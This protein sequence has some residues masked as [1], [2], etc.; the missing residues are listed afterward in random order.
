VVSSLSD[1]GR[2]LY[3]IAIN[4]HFDEYIDG[5]IA[6]RS[7]RP[8]GTATVRILQGTGI[9]AHTGTRLPKGTPWAKQI[10]D[11]RNPRFGRGGPDEV[12]VT[13][14][15]VPISDQLTYRFPPHSVTAFEIPGGIIAAKSRPEPGGPAR[16]QR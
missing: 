6:L 7:F 2:T 14:S 8:A 4:K 1:D 3:A 16:P 11:Q 10:E 5:R 13:T 15:S 9:D 12:K